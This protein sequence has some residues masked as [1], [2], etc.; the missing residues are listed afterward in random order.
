M[1]S[2]AELRTAITGLLG[3]AAAEEEI[4]LTAAAAAAAGGG[5]AD[6]D[7]GGGGEGP[8]RWGAV[9]LLAHT[10]EFKTQQSERIRALRAG[11]VPPAYGEIDHSS[12][13]VYA[14]YAARTAQDVIGSSRATTA[15]LIDGVR[16]LADEDL[17]DPSRH[18]WLNG[19]ML[20]LQIIV[21]G[22]WHPTGH[23]ADFYLRHGQPDRAV[24]LQSHAMAMA[25]Y[26]GAPDAA[27]GMA[28]Y[29]LACAQAQSGLADEAAGTLACAV[30]LNPDLRANAGRDPDLAALRDSGTLA[31]IL[32]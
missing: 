7:G 27:R 26:L 17:L 32:G 15:C 25:R 10:T 9:P 4:L 20:W 8:H 24:A 28:A 30:A 13:S 11:Q 21:R 29:G 12:A 23:I 31:E 6:G 3:F 16:A 5:G 2:T 1:T 22:F 18:P 14:G 19:R